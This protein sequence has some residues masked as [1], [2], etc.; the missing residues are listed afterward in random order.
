MFGDRMR[1]D[2]EEQ[3]A[4]AEQIAGKLRE[5]GVRGVVLS[6]VDTAGVTRIKTVPVARLAHATRWGVGMSTVFD[7]FLSNDLMTST[8]ELGSPDGDLRLVPD[9]DRLVPLA[10]QPGWAWTPVDRYTQA[11]DVWAACQRSFARR[12]VDAAAAAGLTFQMAVEIEWALGRD[13]VDDFVP[14]CTGPAYGMT[15]LIE[16]GD[17]L[18][19]LLAALEDQGIQ[20]DQ[21]HPEY[22]DGQFEVSV[23][24]T[25]PVSAADDSVLVRQTIRALARRHG[26]RATFAPSVIAGHVGNG[27]HVHL[28]AWKDGRNVFAGGT[29]PFAMSGDGEAIAA[30]ILERLPAL[31]AIGAPSPASYLRLVPSHW[32]G[33]FACWGHETRETALRL[34]T[35]NAGLETTAANLEVKCFDLAANP[36]L[37][38]GALIAAALDGLRPEHRLP[39]PVTGDPARF[40]ADELAARG[41]RRLP[42]TLDEA[43][44]ALSADPALR[45]A[46][47]DTLTDAVLA[48]RRA[49]AD[50]FRETPPED[51]VVALRWVY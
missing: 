19:D 15:R 10:A 20:V 2:P 46:L 1:G 50:R 29:G 41:I 47:G 25:D 8:A 18:R 45:A 42:T 43:T 21:L 37:L 7:V 31:L 33:A 11:G 44:A 14:A 38:V 24:A 12:M 34:V 39:P 49:E 9:L 16:L 35:G 22:S 13:D 17:Y 51:M 23:A 26:L 6:Y 3:Q 30:G 28:S 36:Y 27:G 48:V 4:R 5:D 32:A 40:S